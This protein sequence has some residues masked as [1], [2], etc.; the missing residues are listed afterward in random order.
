MTSSPA[1]A[2]FF[3]DDG[4]GLDRAA[5]AVFDR[6]STEAPGLDRWRVSGDATTAGRIAERVSTGSLFGGGTLVVLTDPGPL[7]RSKEDRDALI[8]LLET[9]APGNGLVILEPNDGSNRRPAG[10][11]AIDKAIRAAGGEVREFKAAKEGQLAAWVEARARERGVTLG[12]GAA[13][14]LAT[15]VGGFVREG[16][17]DRRRQGQLAVGELDKL[18]LYRPDKAVSVDDVKALVAEVVPGSTWAFLDAF[19]QRR[20]GRALELLDPLLDGTPELVVMVQLHRRLRELIEVADHLA[21]GASPGSLVRTLGLKPFRAEKLVEQARTWTQDE[22][23]DALQGL[24]ELDATLRGA[25]GTPAGD[26]QR[27]LA[28]VL[29]IGDHAGRRTGGAARAGAPQ[30]EV[31][32]A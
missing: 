19:A 23:D 27:R 7:V 26:A 18:A 20:A 15:R 10:L 28:F 25:P 21:A 14:E 5:D 9:V 32:R 12:P 8:G 31:V 16:D 30:A 29:W 17:V 6:L 3:G 24:V 4:Y 2:Y 11:V 13:R 22:L 1:L